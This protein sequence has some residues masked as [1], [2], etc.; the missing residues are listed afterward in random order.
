[1]RL[2]GH[3]PYGVLMSDNGRGSLI[4]HP[5][6]TITA[7]AELA[8]VDVATLRGWVGLG[9]LATEHRGD[10]EVVQLDEVT[11]LASRHRA[12]RNGA[13][14]DRLRQDDGTVTVV[15]DLVNVADLQALARTRED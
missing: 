8:N 7:A 10:M 1:M 14:R 2:L 12:S 4:R 5:A 6:V 15:G 9:S 3:R 11:A 13:L